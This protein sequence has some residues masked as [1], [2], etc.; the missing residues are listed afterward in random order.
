MAKQSARYVTCLF[1]VLIAACVSFGGICCMMTA[2]KFPTDGLLLLLLFCVGFAAVITLLMRGR[3]TRSLLLFLSVAAVLAILYSVVMTLY[4]EKPAWASLKAVLYWIAQ[5]YDSAYGFGITE[6]WKPQVSGVSLLPGLCVIAGLII[7]V[8]VWTVVQRRNAI[9]AV[10]CALVPLF[11]C[12]VVTDTV[13]ATWAIFLLL[14][15][16]VLLIMTQTVRRRD[17]RDGNRLTAMVLIPCCLLNVLLLRAVPKEDYKANN[18]SVQ[19]ILSDW[20]WALPFMPD[21]PGTGSLPVVSGGVVQGVEVNLDKIGWNIQSDL[22]LMEVT[23]ENSGL[24]YLRGQ[25]YDV[26]T[27]TNWQVR[28]DLEGSRLGWPTNNMQ[29]VQTVEVYVRAIGLRSIRFFPYYVERDSWLEDYE[30]G[31]LLNKDNLKGYIFHQAEPK[32]GRGLASE[33]RLTDALY[34]HYTELPDFTTQSADVLLRGLELDSGLSVGEKAEV[35]ADYVRQTASYDLMTDRM[36]EGQTD[37]A[38][39]FLEEGTTG[40]CVHFATAAA[41]LLR[42]AEIPCRYVTGYLLYAQAGES[43]EVT[44]KQSHAW[45]EYYD[46]NVGWRILE[47]TPSEAQPQ[48]PE[49]TEPPETTEPAETTNPTETTEPSE[50]TGESTRPSQLTRPTQDSETTGADSTGGGGGQAEKPDRTWLLGLLKILGWICGAVAAV[51]LQYALR[52]NRR[53]KRM[54][55]G[56]VNSRALARWR[57]VL[58]LCRI[59]KETPPEALE[60]L[61]EKAKF[62]QHKLTPEEMKTFDHWLRQALGRVKAKKLSLLIR[63][64]WAV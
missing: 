64:V 40:Y 36:P 29:T 12:L 47:P 14:T 50:S 24:L 63:L 22:P 23:A 53:H 21:L 18:G 2:F 49:S 27:G 28:K 35:I 48:P 8:Q 54:H 45:V 3:G 37:F 41:V 20:F 1:S 13:P 38:V 17:E 51:W 46:P 56:P 59:L 9:L 60:A 25:A 11:T 4:V 58:R 30:N 62:S 55:T 19:Q 52:R 43:V 57:E 16:L 5:V 39:W 31:K 10:V 44:E 42:A 32:S 61:A 33:D 26:Y 7:L 15:P 6:G 34:D